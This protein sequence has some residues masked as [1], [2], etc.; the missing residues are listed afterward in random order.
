MGLKKGAILGFLAVLFLHGILFLFLKNYPPFGIQQE[1]FL[2]YA[3]AL[4]SGDFANAISW[5]DS[6]LFPGL[7][8]LIF[9]L[10]FVTQNGFISGLLIILI[11]L[12]LIYFIADHFIQKPIY[13]LW[14]TVFPPIVFEQT[15]KI[16]TELVL[17]ALLML[18]YYFFTKEKYLFSSLISSY[19]TIIRPISICAF[20]PLFL[21]LLRSQQKKLAAKALLIFLIFPL[22]LALFNLYHWGAVFH[23]AAVY[24][25]IDRPSLGFIQ[26]LLDIRR[27]I[28]WGQWR[29]LLSG[30]AYS[31]FT[32]F[33]IF[34]ILKEKKDFLVRGDNFLVKTWA[35]LT[36][37]FIFSIGPTPFL[38]YLSRFSA[39][40]FPLV[41]LANYNYFYSLRKL[42]YLS[43]L[44]SAFAF[45]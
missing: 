39:V 17:I 6:R 9:L 23:Q 20:L 14:L 3:H 21:Y 15:S 44:L 30:L 22:F 40:F 41:L 43:F 11:S 37:V 36:M 8:F 28:A 10:N 24:R 16:S 2:G 25:G 29:I 13:S 19:A 1:N 38:E 26:W 35:V 12:S 18:F 42:F 4:R 5:Y 45:L 7:S 32:F 34:R 27:T 33:L 31:C